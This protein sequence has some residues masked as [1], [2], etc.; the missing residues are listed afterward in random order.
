MVKKSFNLSRKRFPQI[1][2]ESYL[3]SWGLLS[4]SINYSESKILKLCKLKYIWLQRFQLVFLWFLSIKLIIC[5][6]L[7][8]DS[9]FRFYLGDASSFMGGPRTELATIFALQTLPGALIASVFLINSKNKLMNRWLKVFEICESK[10]VD[11]SELNFDEE[12]AL[13]FH[14]RVHHT[15]ILLKFI[16]FGSMIA[17]PP[18][19]LWVYTTRWPK[20]YNYYIWTLV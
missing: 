9:R 18:C 6:F 7:R 3:I 13:R 20:T 12:M 19:F 2:I 17:S 5:C 16:I 14:R 10:N 11:L 15:I 1:N 8:V 4:S